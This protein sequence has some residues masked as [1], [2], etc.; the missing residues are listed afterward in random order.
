[1]SKNNFRSEI[2]ESLNS[3]TINTSKFI[4]YNQL[5][6]LT[7]RYITLDQSFLTN[8]ELN[9]F[10]KSWMSCESHLDLKSIEIDIPLSKA[11]NEIMDLPHEVTKNGYK[12][13]R[14]DGKEAKV[15]FGLWTRPYLYLSIN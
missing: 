9:M 8:Q 1:M 3:L 2:P 15:T 13:K 12:I 11:V 14:C 6:R 5:I 4:N 7:A 10:L